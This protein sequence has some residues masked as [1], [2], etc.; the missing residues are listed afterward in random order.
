MK[1]SDKLLRAL[2]FL[3]LHILLLP[4]IWFLADALIGGAQ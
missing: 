3:A 4:V 1:T 2:G